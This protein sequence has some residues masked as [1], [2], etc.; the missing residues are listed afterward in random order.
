MTIST[1]DY[2]AMLART[3]KTA[4]GEN[5]LAVDK[6]SKLHDAIIQE[7][8][9]RG[10]IAFHGSMAHR[11]KRTLGEP[12]FTILADNGRV[13]F[14]EAKAKAGKLRTE[15]IAVKVWAQKLGHVVHT[16]Y[17]IKQFH[18]ITKG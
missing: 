2:L 1:A 10:W 3:Q 14:I 18:K 12:D 15:Q 16:V 9:A 7:C 4:Q 13:F 11:S 5:H 8:K 6:E 17:N